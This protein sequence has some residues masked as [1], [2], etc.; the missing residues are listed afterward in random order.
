MESKVGHEARKPNPALRA[1]EV[2]VGNWDSVGTHPFVPGK[3]LHGKA[4]FEWLEG[5]AFIVMRSEID[6]PDI[7]SG[8]AIFGSDDAAPDHYM[9]YFDERGVS[10]KY[11]W[12]IEHNVLRWRRNSPDFS[13]RME[14]TIA[15]DGKRMLGRGEMRRNGG[16]W[17]PDL[18]L[19][20]SRSE[21]SAP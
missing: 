8:I 9:L 13:Q 19:T 15:D 14:L 18:E 21:N 11:D 5:G 10:R 6:E 16:A 12:S 4:A 3:T 20:Y 17:E 1:L 7:P 2:V